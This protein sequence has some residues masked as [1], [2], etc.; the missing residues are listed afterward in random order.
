MTEKILTGTD[1]KFS[2]YNP[3]DFKP[4]HFVFEGQGGTAEFY[5]EKGKLKLH[6][7]K[8]PGPCKQFPHIM[9]HVYQ[10][11]KD[12]CTYKFEEIKE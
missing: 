5:I 3:D 7:G 11:V 1:L 12:K 8:K 10:Y 9:D 6:K 2:A 4:I